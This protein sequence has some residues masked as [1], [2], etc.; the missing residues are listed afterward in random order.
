[1]SRIEEQITAIEYNRVMYRIRNSTNENEKIQL[2]SV[3]KWLSDKLDSY[4]RANGSGVQ[5][6]KEAHHTGKVSS[7]VCLVRQ[8]DNQR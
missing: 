2:Q 3:A 7:N 4:R 1:M 5:D 8:T 6:T